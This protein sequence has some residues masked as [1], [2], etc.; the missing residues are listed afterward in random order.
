MFSLLQI[1]LY[2]CQNYFQTN[3]L[4]ISFHNWFILHAFP[5]LPL[6]APLTH[7]ALANSVLPAVSW[8]DSSFNSGCI[9]A[10]SYLCYMCVLVRF[11][12]VRLFATPWTVA[13]QA[14]LS[15]ELPRQEN[16][17]GLPFPFPGVLTD[18][19]IKP[20][21]PAL[22]VNSLLTELPGKPPSDL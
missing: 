14:P 7:P 6:H 16:W 1:L 22:Q 20:W 15:T 19:G 13:H 9:L 3:S 18:T 10:T 21:S 8:H 5:A 11:S 17:S 12:R 4:I 2:Y